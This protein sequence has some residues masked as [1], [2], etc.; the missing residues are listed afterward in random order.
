MALEAT[1]K[2]LRRAQRDIRIDGRSSRRVVGDAVAVEI[3]RVAADRV[4]AGKGLVE[5]HAGGRDPA[6]DRDHAGGA[7]HPAAKHGIGAVVPVLI[8]VGPVE[9]IRPA[10]RPGA[11]T[12]IDLTVA[13]HRV[14]GVGLGLG[15]TAA[16][17]D[18]DCDRRGRPLQ[19]TH[20]DSH[21]MLSLFGSS[22][23]RGRPPETGAS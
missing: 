4:I 16:D 17:E 2:V 13:G 6:A 5:S 22:V 23:S 14:P 18:Q 11:G 7:A 9:P 21:E 19:T 10:H 15:R 1:E 20:S 8:V 3:D 12:V